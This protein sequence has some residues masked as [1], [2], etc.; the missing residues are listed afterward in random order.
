MVQF[1]SGETFEG[2]WTDDGSIGDDV[3]AFRRLPHDW[4]SG[5]RDLPGTR[6]VNSAAF[7][8]HPDS[9]AISVTLSDVA[10]G[11]GI[12][13]AAMCLGEYAGEYGLATVLVRDARAQGLAIRRV[14]LSVD[15]GHAM[16][17]ITDDSGQR[18]ERSCRK[19]GKKLARAAHLVLDLPH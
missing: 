3:V 17:F 19:A 5:D 15:P 6:R 9:Q 1:A 11:L 10:D 14:P 4:I 2:P 18:D 7:Q 16:F 8:P 12:D 13:P